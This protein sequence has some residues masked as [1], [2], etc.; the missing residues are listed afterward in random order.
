MLAGLIL[1][2]NGRLVSTRYL[3]AGPIMPARKQLKR[4]KK[5]MILV[6]TSAVALM[7]VPILVP[8]EIPAREPRVEIRRIR[9]RLLP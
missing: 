7:R 2:K 9:G 8:S 1:F 6:L 5:V 3:M 4:K